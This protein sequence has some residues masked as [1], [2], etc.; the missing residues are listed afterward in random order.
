LA[1]FGPDFLLPQAI[2]STSIYRRWKREIFSTM[3]KTFSPWFRWE[4]PQPLAQSRHGVLLNYQICS[5]RLPE[6]AFLGWCHIRLFASEP[7]TTIPRHKGMSGDQF[8]AQF[9]KFGGR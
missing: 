4:G 5:C 6:L 3:E 7:V 1:Y 9:G 2:K 8:R